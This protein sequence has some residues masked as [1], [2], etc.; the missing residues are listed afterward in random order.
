MAF[1]IVHRVGVPD[2]AIGVHISTSCPLSPH[3]HLRYHQ[4]FIPSLYQ[5]C[6]IHKAVQNRLHFQVKSVVTMIKKS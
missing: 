2:S 5:S 6:W 3:L 1:T 4:H